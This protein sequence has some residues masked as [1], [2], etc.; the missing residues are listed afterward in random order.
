MSSSHT[1]HI[2]PVRL[3]MIGGGE[4]AFIG[5][6]HRM[7]AALDGRY[8]LV[9]G[10]LSIDPAEGVR[11][12]AA[13]GLAA[14]RTYESWQVMLAG[15]AK[16]PAHERVEAIAIVT[17]N[18]THAEIALACV[19]GGFHVLLEK[20]M[21]TTLADARAL[22]EAVREAGRVF[23][24][25]HNYAGNAMVRHARELVRGGAI[26][27]V[28]KVFV[29]YHQGW[30]ATAIENTGQRQ[31]AWRTDPAKSGA[32]AIGDIGSHAHH[33][34]RFVTG[35]EV[36]SLSARL[37]TFVPGRRVDDD[38][39]VLLRF[40]GGASGVLTASR[41]CVGDRNAL[42]LRVHGEKGSIVW[43]QEF[44]EE[45]TLATMDAGVRLLRRGEVPGS[46]RVPAGHPEGYLE[47]FATIYRDAADAI[48]GVP[49]GESLLTSAVDGA[50][51]VAFISACQES[52]A[53][54]GVWI[55]PARVDA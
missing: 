27:A 38:A 4:G 51:G 47:A 16:L 11:S 23:V 40:A 50:V 39:M 30:L 25:T 20:P 1:T 6:V 18:F 26:G 12:G 9:A 52:S 34:A 3:G 32:G 22:V 29:E 31:A 21:T 42:A 41:G 54:D 55:A 24:V 13:L 37:A 43:R 8:V 19:R 49:R 48:R 36:E 10:A 28:R 15:E 45:L 46:S 33:L 2:P 5:G 44:P 14:A 35:L 53:R 17:P 7:A